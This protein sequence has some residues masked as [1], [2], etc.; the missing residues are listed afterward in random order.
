MIFS[1]RIYNTINFIILIMLLS[2]VFYPAKKVLALSGREIME[3]VNARDVGD[4][5]SGEMEMIL[6]DK[7][8][9]MRIRKLKTF[10]GKKGKDTLSLMFFISPADVKNTGFLTYDYKKSGKDD[11]QWLYL[12]ALRN[13][14]TY[15]RR[16]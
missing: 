9:K 5:S 6:I 2:G 1:K 3:K 14:K 4:S 16:R 15:C 7:K 11:D 10:G 12:P 8:G 13:N